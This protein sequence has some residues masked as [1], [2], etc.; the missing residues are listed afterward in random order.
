MWCN[1]PHIP[2][3]WDNFITK[4]FGK[5]NVKRRKNLLY[6][7]TTKEKGLS[8]TTCRIW[9]KFKNN[10]G[11]PK[12]MRKYHQYPK[13]KNSSSWVIGRNPYINF[14]FNILTKAEDRG[15]TIRLKKSRSDKQG[16]LELY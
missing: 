9:K 11:H 14:E 10:Q 12:V 2:Q 3:L 1:E 5:S 4:N 16:R 6:L 15:R 8:G 7:Q 13:D